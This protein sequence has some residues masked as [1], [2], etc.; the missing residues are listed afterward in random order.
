METTHF[1]HRPSAVVQTIMTAYSTLL[2]QA[3]GH[4]KGGTGVVSTV[5]RVASLEGPDLAAALQQGGGVPALLVFF[6]GGTYS[7]KGTGRGNYLDTLNY[8]ILCISGKSTNVGDRLAEGEVD[9]D[10][11]LE[12]GVEELQDW[13]FYLG[14]R[15]LRTAGLN[16]STA[17]RHSQVF[18]MKP[19]NYIGSVEFHGQREVDVYD[20]TLA[21]S[22]L[23]L[24]IV[25]SP[26]DPDDLWE[27]D[28]ETPR[29]EW[30]P[31]TGGVTTP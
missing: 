25:H 27:A 13:A 31:E 8:M 29:S 23:S 10:E 9:P 28:N 1:S 19:E 18:R 22:L 11:A 5:A 30:P 21:N 14:L 7:V 26:T 4:R 12:P 2:K 6:S 15:A 24:G 3:G 17:V 20:D 16:M